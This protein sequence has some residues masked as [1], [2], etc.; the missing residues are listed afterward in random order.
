M[1]GKQLSPDKRR[2]VI[3]LFSKGKTWEFGAGLLGP[4]FQG[5]AL[6]RARRAPRPGGRVPGCSA[7]QP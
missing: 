6:K 4:L 7:K 1:Q 2:E 5:G 3:R